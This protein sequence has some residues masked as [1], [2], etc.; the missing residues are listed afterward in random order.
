MEIDRFTTLFVW[1]SV[2]ANITIPAEAFPLGTLLSAQPGTR[3][4][5]ETIVP[6]AED[7]IPYFWVR[8]PAVETVTTE[9]GNP[10]GVE[11]IEVVDEISDEALC[12]VRWTEDVGGLVA[13]IA[14]TEATILRGTGGGDRWEFQLRF[15][16]YDGLSAFYQD[17]QQRGIAI[18]LERVHNPI[19]QSDDPLTDAQREALLIALEEGYFSVPRET[20]LEGLA[21]RLGISDSAVSQRIRRGLTQLL[22]LSLRNA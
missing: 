11:S 5:L 10:A 14:A 20:T 17:A 21:G 8:N 7:M 3:V 4:R 12:R 19:D 9:I 13:S 15:P 2:I 16:D 6:T 22:A 18:D 1:M